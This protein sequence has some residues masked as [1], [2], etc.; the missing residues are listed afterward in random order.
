MKLLKRR[1]LKTLEKFDFHSE[2]NKDD[3]NMR[4][5]MQTTSSDETI[6]SPYH[7]LYAK[8]LVKLII[9]EPMLKSWLN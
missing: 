3:R 5:K 1:K 8:M 9:R 2:Y 7:C 4:L 6:T